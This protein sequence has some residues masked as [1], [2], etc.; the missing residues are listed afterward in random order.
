MENV[1]ILYGHLN[2]FMAIGNILW[3]FVTFGG[4]LV[5]FSPFWY[6][7]PRKIWQPCY[8]HKQRKHS[9]TTLGFLRRLGANSS[10]GTLIFAPRQ[11]WRL[12]LVLRRGVG[13]NLRL[14]FF[15]KLPSEPGGLVQ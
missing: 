10:L 5:Y 11:F 1:G 2:Y 6:F 8:V 14:D 3:P 13:A 12:L 4:H 9:T 7:E 15:K